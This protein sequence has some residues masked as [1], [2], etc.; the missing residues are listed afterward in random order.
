MHLK[1]EMLNT[2]FLFSVIKLN[3]EKDKLY[4]KN[5]SDAFILKENDKFF[6]FKALD[7]IQKYNIRKFL[8]NELLNKS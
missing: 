3:Y 4:E 7:N 6:V 1:P 8:E 5:N 2:D